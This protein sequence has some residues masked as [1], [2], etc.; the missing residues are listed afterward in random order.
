MYSSSGWRYSKGTWVL[1]PVS[2]RF[3][4][5]MIVLTETGS[6]SNNT[7]IS[8]GGERCSYPFAVSNVISWAYAI[9]E[10]AC[11]LSFISPSN[12]LHPPVFI[13]LP[14]SSSFLVQTVVQF[15]RR[16]QIIALPWLDL[17]FSRARARVTLWQNSGERCIQLRRVGARMVP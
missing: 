11:T 13:F 8:V 15:L 12:V 6:Y 10:T 7:G 1:S 5:I 4:A 2:H 9:I 14:F 17:D 3:D 16:V